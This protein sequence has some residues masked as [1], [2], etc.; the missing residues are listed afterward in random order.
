MNLGAH[1]HLALVQDLRMALS[2]DEL[3]LHFQPRLNGVG[4]RILGAE[5]LVRWQAPGQ[6]LVYPTNF[7]AIAEDTGLIVDIGRWVLRR[8]LCRGSRGAGAGHKSLVIS[9][10]ASPHEL[11]QERYRTMC[12]RR[13]AKSTFPRS[14]PGNRDH[15]KHGGAGAPR[16]IRMLVLADMGVNIAIDDFGTGYSNLRYLQRFRHSG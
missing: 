10:N 5:A 1:E 13:C 7:I 8:C 14:H 16:L 2:R 15:R 9:I 11:Q 3:L 6:P 12:S 4:G